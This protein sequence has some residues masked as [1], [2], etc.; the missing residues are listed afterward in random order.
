ME[1][2]KFMES[3]FMSSLQS[4]LGTHVPAIIGAILIL[5]VGWFVA[6]VVRAGTRKSLSLLKVNQRISETTEE[7]L[8]VEKGVGVGVFWF[9]MLMT[10]IGVFNTLN[11]EIVSLSATWFLGIDFNQPH[12]PIAMLINLLIDIR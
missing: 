12:T 6:V 8:D 1:V 2:T 9:V 10:F 11:L 7:K 4:T 5:I 3:E